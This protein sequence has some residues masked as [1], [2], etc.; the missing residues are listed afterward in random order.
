MIAK[1]FDYNELKIV[2]YPDPR[3]KV[4]AEAIE[5]ITPEII[6]LANRMVELMVESSGVGLAAPQVGVSLRLIV[7]SLSGKKEDAEVLVNPNVTN[8]N[9]WSEMEEGCLSI[10]GVRATVKRAA[11][12][13]VEAMDLEGNQFMMDAVELLATI[14]QHETDHLNGILFIDRLNPITKMGCRK[15]IKC[16]EEE[17]KQ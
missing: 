8:L 2:S 14:L 3:L 15:A 12:C 17:W 5:A 7:I 9:G 16:L 11:A 13:T 4:K 10:P 6:G 1:P